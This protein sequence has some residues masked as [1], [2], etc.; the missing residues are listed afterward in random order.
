M[1]RVYTVIIDEK[2]QTVFVY[3]GEA[4]VEVIGNNL[5][6]QIFNIGTTIYQLQKVNDSHNIRSGN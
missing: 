5:T 3:R 4:F 6:E 2:D 1:K